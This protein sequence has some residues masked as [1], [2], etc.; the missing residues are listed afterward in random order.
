MNIKEF[1]EK[2]HELIS[3]L[4][5]AILGATRGSM[6]GVNDCEKMIM[7]LQPPTP[8]TCNSCTH[9]TTND[10]RINNCRNIKSPLFNM[11]LDDKDIQEL[12]CTKHSDYEVKNG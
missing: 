6:D 11:S 4:Y 9:V 10:C 7:R 5:L 12:T 3:A 1:N 8:P 2:K